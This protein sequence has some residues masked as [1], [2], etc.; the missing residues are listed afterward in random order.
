MKDKSRYISSV[1]V[2]LLAGFICFMF[3]Q[4]IDNNVRSSIKTVLSSNDFNNMDEQYLSTDCFSFNSVSKKSDSKIN[5][6]KSK[7]YIKKRNTIEF[8]DKDV[9]IPGEELFSN[10]ISNNQAKFSKPVADK[11]L[12]FTSELNNLI[13]GDISKYSTKP[14]R[15]VR[16]KRSPGIEVA[17]SKGMK[18]SLNLLHKNAVEFDLGN[19][20]EYNYVTEENSPAPVKNLKEKK[21]KPQSYKSDIHY[22]TGNSYNS[23]SSCNSNN[24]TETKE[25]TGYK[26]EYKNNTGYIEKVKIKI[27][28]P[29]VKVRI[30]KEEADEQEISIPGENTDDD[31]MQ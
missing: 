12:D 29:K 2:S 6:K 20:F 23:N 3:G 26:V 22:N 10:Y 30:E 14:G 13:K 1:I 28:A 5:K 24:Q 16:N 17:D 21:N 25:C 11:N 8:K 27:I 15:E 31:S 18:S 19:G 9:T 4:D 7:F